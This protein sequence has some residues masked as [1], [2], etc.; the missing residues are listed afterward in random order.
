M[1]SLLEIANVPRTVEVRGLKIEVTGI[2][3]MGL[4]KLMARF[5]EIGQLFSG[6]VP[7]KEELTKLAPGALAAFIAAGTGKP[8][9]EEAEKIA[10]GLGLGEQL[11]LVDEIMRLTFPRGVG[12][13]VAKLQALGLLGAVDPRSLQPSPD[14]P[15]N[16]SPPD[17]PT[18]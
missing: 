5:P 14:T 12:P 18:P 9:D 10:G 11:D 1:A 3:A 16:S 13:F 2:S 7:E 15:K 17:T 4:T 8:G 6:I